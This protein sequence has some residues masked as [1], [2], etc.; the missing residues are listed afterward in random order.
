MNNRILSIRKDAKLT[1]E[2]FG[3]RIGGLS[4]NYVWMIEKGER[5]PSDR[6]I[7]DICREFNV[8]EEWLRFGTGEKYMPISRDVQ[9]EEFLGEILK[10][11]HS[12]FKKRLISALA[13]LSESEWELLEK[14]MREIVLGDEEKN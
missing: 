10:E 2:E 1:Q 9:I 12:N 14:K 13:K 5:I 7:N 8:N 3:S 6:T 11:E 4:R